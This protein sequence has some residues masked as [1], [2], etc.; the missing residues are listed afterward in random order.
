MTRAPCYDYIVAGGGSAGCLAAARLA[1]EFGLSVLLLEA[2]PIDATWILHVP[3]GFARLLHN[4]KYMRHHVAIPQL[5]LDGRTPCIPQALVLGGGSS[6]NAQAYMRG[7][8][9][10]YD[11]W[12][13]IAGSTLWSW[14]CMLPH[15]RR[16][17]GNQVFNNALHSG[18]GPLKVSY[19]AF[20]CELS[21]IYVRTLQGMGLPLTT[22]F[23]NGS[24]QGVGYLQVTARDGRRCSAVDAFLR[25]AEGCGRIQVVTLARVDRVILEN[26]RA[27]GVEYI[28]YGQKY[29]AR[30][31][32]EVLLAAGAFG[33]PQLLMLS[34]IG[35][36]NHLKRHGIRT[37]VDLPSVGANLQDHPGASVV[38]ATRGRYGYFGEDRGLRLLRNLA[39]YA[40]FRR[41]P[42]ATNGVETC[43]YHVPEDGNGDPVVQIYCVPT[44]GYVDADASK[45]ARPPGMT[46][47]AVLLRP[48][49][50]G[51][52]RLR[53]ADPAAPPLVNPNYL[54][55]EEDVQHLRLGLRAAREILLHRP[56][57][58]IVLEEVSPGLVATTDADL[59]A[60]LR[61]TVKTD[62]HPV[63]TCRMGHDEDPAAVVRE[64]LRVRGIDRL[65]VIDA[66]IM[67]KIVSANTN[68]P[69]MAI[70]DRAVSIM[71][72]ATPDPSRPGA[73]TTDQQHSTP[74][75]AVP[76]GSRVRGS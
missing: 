40:L 51:C 61:R 46:L 14:E 1:S 36:S 54:A 45:I 12:E 26:G 11:A 3:S 48:R 52:V 30:A 9:A 2:G 18:E 44:T 73:A 57:A 16:L 71:Q 17:E 34:G 67:P 31:D 76:Q 5:Q 13:A 75:F 64:D 60:H 28:R 72:S 6:V 43:S 10:D 21:H 32:R 62:Y 70:A 42:A 49:S 47:H 8:A 15:F 41:G 25:P 19:P 59:A 53:S 27:I 35:P 38:V 24:P 29:I 20:T 56:L 68:A 55:E 7:R 58:D 23:N 37:V 33:S 22:D 74:V 4:R 63:G 39:E 66:S 69:T 65:R 50:V